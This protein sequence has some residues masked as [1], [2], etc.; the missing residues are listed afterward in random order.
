MALVDPTIALSYRAPNIQP[1]NMMADYAAIQQI[2]GGQRQGEL[3]QYQLGAAQRAEK[4]QN[5]LAGAYAQ[6]T[7]PATGAI[8]YNKLRTLVAGGGAGAQIPGIEKTRRE[9]ET[10]ALTQQEAAFKVQKS[11][12]DFIAQA[13]RDTSQNPSDANITA[14]KEDLAANPLFSEVEKKQ[15]MAGA[16]R[17]LAMPVGERRAMMSSQGASAAELKP[18]IQQQNVGGTMRALSVPAFGGAATV[19]PGS[20]VAATMTPA[21]IEQGRRDQQRLGLESQRVALDVQKQAQAS[22]PAFV[23]KMASAKTTGEAAAKD[24]LLA[25]KVLPQVVS[26]ANQTLALIDTMIGQRDDK[27]NLVKGAAPHPGFQATVGASLTPGMR[28]VPGSDASDFQS[29]FD[30]VKGGAF[31]QAFETLK[32][33]G[34]ITEK[35]GE[36]GTA[37]LNRMN[38]AQSEKEFVTAAREFQNVVR[39]GVQRAQ[40]KV[41]AAAAAGGGWSVVK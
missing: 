16:D 35:E 34:A 38:L 17:L 18:T 31:L 30:Q 23:Q 11:K 4:T 5:V 28:F 41:P 14:Y 20:E 37:A 6:A 36:K 32:G 1:Q 19:V 13:K 29:Y 25:A 21:Q 33:G 22:D 24:Q 9:M 8:D 7:D 15:M 26:T 3:A 12:S 2:Q 27:G 40:A 39:A 10:A